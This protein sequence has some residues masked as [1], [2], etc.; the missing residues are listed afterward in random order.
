LTAPRSP[1]HLAG[2]GYTYDGELD[3]QMKPSGLGVMTMGENGKD[4]IAGR[5]TPDG[6][7]YLVSGGDTKP[8]GIKGR[9]TV[10]M[11]NP[12]KLDGAL[13]SFQ[14]TK[15][16]SFRV[17]MLGDNRLVGIVGLSTTHT[18]VQWKD[19]FA[20]EEKQVDG[21][22]VF[23]VGRKQAWGR[24][25][26]SDGVYLG[27]ITDG[28]PDGCGVWKWRTGPKEVGFYT[29]GAKQAG[30]LPEACKNPHYQR[31]IDLDAVAKNGPRALPQ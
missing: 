8:D 27:Q 5:F 23:T 13:A 9:F 24:I 28:K 6:G 18:G 4:I 7:N 11:A 15:E 31:P 26:R 17:E 14:P 19:G 29:A 3:A 25:D 16:I 20:G 21:T 2:L 12:P 1:F 22:E 30:D 10:S